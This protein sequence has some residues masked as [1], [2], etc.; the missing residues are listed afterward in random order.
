M[1]PHACLETIRRLMKQVLNRGSYCGEDDEREYDLEQ[2]VEHVQNL[3]QWMS[4][5]GFSP[6]SAT[7]LGQTPIE[8]WA[9]V[10]PG[11]IIDSVHRTEKSAEERRYILDI[12]V[13]ALRLNP[14]NARVAHLVELRRVSLATRSAADNPSMKE[15]GR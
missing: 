6:W 13:P 7:M 5:G 8:A 15:P 10:E 12:P 9:V 11:D 4:R 3:D 1:D 2:F 14:T